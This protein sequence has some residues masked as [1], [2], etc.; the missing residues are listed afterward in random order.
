MAAPT[1]SIV[2]ADTALRTGETSLVTFTFSE[3]VLDFNNADVTV[4]NGAL[5]SVSSADGG[6]TWTATLTPDTA[7]TDT[8]NVIT[9]DKSGV[10]DAGATPG[11]GTTD[12]NNY[13]IDTARPTASVVVADTALAAGETS[14]VTITFSEAV[15]GLTNADLTVANGALSAVSSADGGITWTATLT[16]TADI[17]D[18]TNVITLDNTGV[19]DAAGNAGAG[20]TDSNNYAIDT[21]RP[22]VSIVV[23][24]AALTAGETSAVTITFSE[25]VVGFT[26]ADLTVANG[27]LSAVSSADGG[28]T[29]TATLTPTAA[30]ADTTNVITLD[31]TGVADAAGNAGTGTT[32]SNNYAIDTTVTP[33]PPPPPPTSIPGTTGSDAI[34]GNSLNNVISAGAGNDTASG[35]DGADEL[36]GGE[37]LDSLQ[38][39]AGADSVEGGAGDDAV[40]GGKDNDFVHGN[41]GADYVTGDLGNDTAHGGKDSDLVHGRE[42]DDIVSGDDGDDI[43][44]GGKGDDYVLGGAGSDF[45]SGDVGNDT[46]SGGAGADL[47]HTFVGAGLDVVVDFSVAEGDRVILAPGSQYSVAQVEANTVITLSGG[48]QLILQAIQ[49][50]AL[51][52]GWIIGA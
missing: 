49:M 45:V 9:V 30:I 42:G 6:V 25:A 41:A 50:D 1:V 15:V 14:A 38:G 28:V 21:A 24:D 8:T 47:F 16:P 10:T 18:T 52:D 2:V 12:S 37:G 34:T 5:S 51:T 39:N 27:A 32:D 11:V 3:Q 40:L 31:N 23:A 13:A 22:T 4:A 48:D 46:V 35:Q 17:A 19:A 43:V 44:R 29:W 7:I 33:P 26:N 36:S 20:T